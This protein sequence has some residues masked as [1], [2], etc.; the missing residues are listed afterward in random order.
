[1]VSRHA[2]VVALL[3]SEAVSSAQEAGAAGA[4]V[5]SL[6]EHSRAVMIASDPPVHTRRREAVAPALLPAELR[7]LA[8]A[9]EARVGELLDALPATGAEVDLVPALT[10]RVPART[11]LDLLG[12]DHADEAPV[13]AWTGAFSD[14]ISPWAGPDGE[15]TAGAALAE[16]RDHLRPILAD[17]DA[18]PRPDLLSALA[19]NPALDDDEALQQAVL[20][21]TAGLDTTA[22]LLAS[23]VAV[24]AADPELWA[25][26]VADPD[27]MGPEHRRGD[28]ALGEPGAVRDAPP[29]RP[30]SRSRGRRSPAARRCCWR[31]APPTAT[32]G[33]SP[34][35][36][37]SSPPASSA[38]SVAT[39]RSAAACT[40]ASGRR[41]PGSRA[42]SCSGP[43]PS[44][45]RA[46]G[47][48]PRCGPAPAVPPGPRGRDRRPGLSRGAGR[49]ARPRQPATAGSATPT[50]GSSVAACSPAS[51][52]MSAISRRHAT[53]SRSALVCT[54]ARRSRCST[55]SV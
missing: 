19:T 41:W 9:I 52:T 32:S 42:R 47:W 53:L 3:K 8:A 28:A 37:A 16:L 20:L 51:P 26:L 33:S 40:A 6:A 31:W 11:L 1:M 18:R 36:T 48:P 45:T 27:P 4:P 24:A 38:A 23:A 30:R 54:S 17:R 5:A 13:R 50:S 44:G 12:L 25:R 2:D 21:C 34:T 7:P 29:R 14:G 43:W 15:A 39:S 49:Q 22:D 46:S 35:P 10:A 55:I